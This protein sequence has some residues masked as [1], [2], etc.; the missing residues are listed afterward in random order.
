MVYIVLMRNGL[1]F[2]LVLLVV[3]ALAGSITSAEEDQCRTTYR[4]IVV[5]SELAS[6][7]VWLNAFRR[8]KSVK[9]VSTSMFKE[10]QEREAVV[11]PPLDLCG[12]ECGEPG[13]VGTIFRSVPN[14][15]RESYPDRSYCE[16]LLHKTKSEPLRFTKVLGSDVEDVVDWIASFSRGSGK[17]GKVLYRQCDRSCSPQ[18]EYMIRADQQQMVVE[19]SVVCGHA[20]DKRDTQYELRYGFRWK[21]LGGA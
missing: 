21:C 12:S 9:R 19:A 17:E 11:V 10:A 15:Y 8:K 2:F 13:L 4:D 5:R 7:S 14:V 1:L 6:A 18:Y 16:E 20:R 3:L